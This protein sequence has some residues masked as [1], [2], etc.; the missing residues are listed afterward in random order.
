MASPSFRPPLSIDPGGEDDF[1]TISL[2]STDPGDQDEDK[3]WLVENIFAEQPHPERPG[4]SQYL[5]KWDG[6]PMD[7]CTWEPTEHLGQGLLEGWERRK[8]AVEAG[9][10]EAFDLE[11]W[12][13]ACREKDERHERRNAK[14]KRLGLKLTAPF[15]LPSTSP[16]EENSI[17]PTTVSPITRYDEPGIDDN[18]IQKKGDSNQTGLT[19]T[20]EAKPK[21]KPKDVVKR[22]NSRDNLPKK[23][24]LPKKITPV[25]PPKLPPRTLEAAR[26]APGKGTPGTT[27]TGYQGTARKP[28]DG[29]NSGSSKPSGKMPTSTSLAHKFSAKRS[30]SNGLRPL[31]PVAPKQTPNIFIG[32]KER[33]KRTNLSDAMDDHSKTP[34]TFSSMRR[35]NM[36]KKRGIEKSDRYHPDLS[37][38]P[39]HFIVTPGPNDRPKAD[40]INKAGQT[41]PHG[42]S[43]PTDQ[44]PIVESP[45][46]MSPTDMSPTTPAPKARK[47]SV[48]FTDVSDAIPKDVPMGGTVE[49][50][51]GRTEG[52]LHAA[53]HPHLGT[54]SPPARRLSLATY[55]ERGQTQVVLKKAVFGKEGSDPIRVLFSNMSRQNQ[56]WLTSF[57][58]QEALYFNSV[59]A[60]YNFIPHK[61]GLI[62]EIVS[63]GTVESYSQNII[64]TL[65]TVAENLQRDSFGSHLVTERFSI[66]VYPS[67][68]DGWSGLG[69]EKHDSES[70]LRY[71]IYKS[72]IDA[73]HHLPRSIPRAPAPLT[74]VSQGSHGQVLIKDLFG[75]DFAQFLP[76]DPKQK[77]NQV[78]MLLF[79][80]REVQVRNIIKLWLRS[81][82]PNCR[83]FSHELQDSWV[84]FHETVRAGAAG[85]IILHEDIAVSI[86]KLPRAQYLTEYTFW[87][88]STGQYN[89]PRFPSDVYDPIEPGTL[90]MTRLFPYGRAFLITPSFALSD[91]GRLVDFLNWFKAYCRNPHYL[92]MA[93]A[94]FPDYLEA[95]TLEK[96][97]EREEISQKHE[98]DPRL[99]NILEELGLS[100]K[101]LDDRFRA[102]EILQ[103][104]MGSAG[105]ENTDEDIRKVEWITDSI[106]PNDEQSLVNWFC[107]WS[108]TKC[109]RYR[110]FT[111]L[112]SGKTKNKAAYRNI[113]IPV[114]TQETVSN[115]DLA[116]AREDQLRRAR[117][118]AELAR[119]AIG[120]GQETTVQNHANAKTISN[121]S[122][123]FDDISP[124][125]HSTINHLPN[126][127]KWL[128]IHR[129]PISWLH[130]Q[131][132][133]HFGDPRCTHDTFKNWFGGT[134]IAASF[135]NTWVG[136]FHTIDDEWDA[137]T[138]AR[139]YRN[140]PWIAALRPINPHYR[141]FEKM[142]LF[143]W[144]VSFEARGRGSK[145]RP[146]LLAMQ[147]RLINFIR[148]QLPLRE[149]DQSLDLVYISSKTSIQ[150]RPGDSLLDITCQRLEEMA[151]NS[152]I[153]LP[154]F[155][156]LLPSR[157]WIEVPKRDWDMP[158]T[159]EQSALLEIEK[160]HTTIRR[161]PCDENRPERS[162]FHAPRPN[163]QAP[164][165]T[166]CTNHLYECAL[167]ARAD[168]GSCKIMTYRYKSTLDWYHDMK[169]EGRDATHVL[170]DSADK[171]IERLPSIRK[172]QA[173]NEK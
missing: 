29:S 47:K 145:N 140:H 132:A 26:P 19:P 120:L 60:S 114:Y 125:L 96:E 151:V 127:P 33:K 1:D 156:N 46:A 141:C 90:Q 17:S 64:A 173:I 167:S 72:P 117:E 14:R 130:V 78:F 55:Q 22:K 43:T 3:E 166:R 21:S 89:P 150:Q 100:R 164:M 67:Q 144:D 154:P 112:G 51:A 104:I 80:D 15:P 84:K 103:D 172:I 124:R 74:A 12:Y 101:T 66:L 155:E 106:D 86:R 5:I 97:Q 102:W 159:N 56:P 79:P 40:Q 9:E 131:M 49:D 2:T 25:P 52:G 119:D 30:A 160:Q 57:I 10:L 75:L 121:T 163:T 61:S 20:S 8:S 6:F 48:R 123:H 76:Q 11:I 68:C 92:I 24:F 161:H 139:A 105:D 91:P 53:E 157:G 135:F 153:W 45:T 142:E 93:C 54:T 165:A 39:A 94:N 122:R 62:E 82:Q 134:P 148:D 77:D 146:P 87:N 88:L 115:P 95:V 7:Q 13:S 98:H 109:D 27:M 149:A 58:A 99:D 44:S 162:I 69:V 113:E 28:S 50:M 126:F 116:I 70:P 71:I 35:M 133:D 81:C 36:A 63:S 59:C 107:W 23:P 41:K 32:G 129:T 111:V 158:N 38:I 31:L 37:Q 83:I 152:K 128:K 65:K 170:V 73:K 169:V 85:T 110:K 108:A 147:R 42:P 16:V 4:E 136:L 137:T 143:I 18:I 118:A 171:V 34:K 168:D 138:P